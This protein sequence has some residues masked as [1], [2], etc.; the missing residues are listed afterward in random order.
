VQLLKVRV[1]EQDR[2]KDLM[3]EGSFLL[4]RLDKTVEKVFV[5]ELFPKGDLFKAPIQRQLHRNRTGR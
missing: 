1:F 4:L 3:Q 2:I 5:D